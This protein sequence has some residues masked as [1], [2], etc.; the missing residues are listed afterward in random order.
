MDLKRER[1]VQVTSGLGLTFCDRWGWPE[2]K[3]E[4]IRGGGMSLLFAGCHSRQ[5]N[6]SI[7]ESRA[8]GVGWE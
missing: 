6:Q 5:E 2:M 1:G 7:G 4:V 8:T 3:K